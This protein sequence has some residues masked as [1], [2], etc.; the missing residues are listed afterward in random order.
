MLVAEKDF[1]GRQSA[2]LRELL[3]VDPFPMKR[4]ILYHQITVHSSELLDLA[5][6]TSWLLEIISAKDL[7]KVD[8]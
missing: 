3:D 8:M 5:Y 2:P 6:G 1:L 4:Q 7:L